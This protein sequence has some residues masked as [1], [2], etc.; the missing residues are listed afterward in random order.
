MY[1]Q[2]NCPGNLSFDH[3]FCSEFH[4]ILITKIIIKSDVNNFNC[5]T[6]CNA[7]SIEIYLINIECMRDSLH[8]FSSRISSYTVATLHIFEC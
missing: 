8:S 5:V 1:Y 3:I 7:F 2:V 6:K 4:M